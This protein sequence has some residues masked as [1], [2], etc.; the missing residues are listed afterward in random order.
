M[1]LVEKIKRLCNA[2]GISVP[3]LEDAL[4]FGAGTIS[5]WKKSA[6]G[7]DKLV[8]VAEYFQVS[9]DYLLGIENSNYYTNEETAKLAQ[10]VY[11]NPDLRILFDASRDL[12]PED[13]RFVVDMV[14]RMKRGDIN[15]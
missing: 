7:S 1:V 4:G 10:E 3:K 8:K 12:R 15:E 14:K 5:K 2:R 6:P 11:D 13:I 9:T